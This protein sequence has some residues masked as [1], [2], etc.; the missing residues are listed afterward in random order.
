MMKYSDG[1]D[2]R[3]GFTKTPPCKAVSEAMRF[4]I[5]RTAAIVAA[6]SVRRW[7]GWGMAAKLG[8]L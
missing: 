5:R 8:G 3:G 4:G 6:A 2:W 7:I 1:H